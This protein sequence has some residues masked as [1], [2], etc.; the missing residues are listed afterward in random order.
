MTG[1]TSGTTYYFSAWG[2]YAAGGGIDWFS[3]TY[4][5]AAC[6]TPASVTLPTFTP[7]TDTHPLAPD[8]SGL[9]GM[10]GYDI[11]IWVAS[12]MFFTPA[13]FLQIIALMIIGLFSVGIAI[14]TRSM[15]VTIL[16]VLI[17]CVAGYIVGLVPMFAIFL[18]AA[19]AAPIAYIKG[20]QSYG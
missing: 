19:I 15:P 14:H 13:V 8:S 17:M 6:T 12:T 16:V 9:S 20:A 5:E 4:G 11:G 10:P 2:Y 3:L 18:Y 1:L 7:P